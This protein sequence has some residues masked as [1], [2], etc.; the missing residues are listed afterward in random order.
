MAGPIQFRS[1]SFYGYLASIRKLPD[2]FYAL[3]GFCSKRRHFSYW[4]GNRGVARRR[5]WVPPR[6]ASRSVI[7]PAEASAATVEGSG[8]V[9]WRSHRPRTEKD[10]FRMETIYGARP[11]SW[12]N[13]SA[14]CA[15][16]FSFRIKGAI[17]GGT[18]Q[19]TFESTVRPGTSS[20]RPIH[21]KSPAW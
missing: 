13:S 16:Y 8:Q 10:P 6:G 19:T 18:N 3:R 11:F 9:G 7:E 17:S 5:T 14:G 21:R 12:A 15:R 4:Q 2:K 1:A 20:F